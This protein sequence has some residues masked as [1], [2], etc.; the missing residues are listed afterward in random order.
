MWEKMQNF[1]KQIDK[2]TL[3]PTCLFKKVLLIYLIK[4]IYHKMIYDNKHT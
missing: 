1:L 2:V 4:N 3:V